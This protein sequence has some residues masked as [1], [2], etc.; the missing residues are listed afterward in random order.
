MKEALPLIQYTVKTSSV[1]YYLHNNCQLIWQ[2]QECLLTN[3]LVRGGLIGYM[4]Y[5]FEKALASVIIQLLLGNLFFKL[6]LGLV[7]IVFAFLVLNKCTAVA[8]VM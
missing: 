7:K 8:G 2:P 4:F 6:H 5:H 3:I 1:D